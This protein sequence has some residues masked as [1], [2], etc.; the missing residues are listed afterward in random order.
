MNLN[1]KSKL[2]ILITLTI[3][4]PIT[5][6]AYLYY[7]N[8]ITGY[9]VDSFI[10]T[11]NDYKIIDLKLKEYNNNLHH[12]SNH[13]VN[14][15][16]IKSIINLISNYEDK[17]N[18]DDILFD[19]Q[20][21]KLL[22]LV[23]LQLKLKQNISFV[24]FDKNGEVIVMKRVLNGRKI[25]GI[26]SHV[27]KTHFIDL[28]TNIS[29]KIPKHRKA[30]SDNAK[31]I[32]IVL[33]KYGFALVYSQKIYMNDEFIGYIRVKQ[34]VTQINIS[35]IVK[36]LNNKFSFLSN[37]LLIGNYNNIDK[38]FIIKNGTLKN[39][40]IKTIDISETKQYFFNIHYINVLN[41]QRLYFVSAYDKKA[42]I[43]KINILKNN[44]FLAILISVVLSFLIAL[45]FL[46]IIILNPLN[47]LMIGIEKLKNK[48]YKPILLNQKD[49]FG[50]IAIE[51]NSLLENLENSFNKNK[52]SI[53]N[54]T[55][56][57][58][59]AIETIAIFDENKNIIQINES[60][61][62]MFKF[63]D[64]KEALDTNI[65]VFIP[66]HEAIKIEE[67]LTHNIT[68]QY[69]VDLKRI[70]KTIFPALVAGKN[71]LRNGKTYRITTVIDLTEIKQKDQQMFHQSRLAQM[72]EMISMIAHQWRQPLNSI[73]LTSS[74]LKFKCMMD[75]FDQDLFEKELDLIDGYSQHLS[76][77]ID[78]FRGFFKNN[79][80]KEI[81]TLEEIVDSTLDIVK[82][83]VENRNIKIITNF[84]CKKELKTYPSEIKQVILN[85]IKNA[86]D[87]LLDNEI[88]N[89]T[90][91]IE[92]LYD[93]NLDNKI[94][95]I[96]DNAGGIPEDIINNIFDPYFSTK[97][98]KDGTGLGLY[99]SKT[100]IEDHCG[101]KLSVVNDNDGAVFYITL[102]SEEKCEL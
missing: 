46:N 23:S 24:L 34:L 52:E 65:K 15:K 72:G 59:T 2:L 68:K 92:T 13:I 1:L 56:L 101:G 80:E 48:I 22:H 16:H 75:D 97:L 81:I 12:I 86:E 89:P 79:K 57:V 9:K 31:N 17:N 7:I 99:M 32:S 18:Y 10:S 88:K 67:I 20:K 50:K 41:N 94:L 29:S 39:N 4:I 61:I 54:F 102:I 53:E 78:D 60:G 19:E 6:M 63:R 91:T 74:N 30:S 64:L 36:T 37:D 21:K 73:S 96:K 44:I 69:E 100:I 43:D 35:S 51:F 77:T 76:K 70:D 14:S 93:N 3:L 71:I 58:D 83:S 33:D 95:I 42:L 84:N 47:K 85:I 82:V 11:K 90:I 49:E 98:E 66:E 40:K 55:N 27:G 62:K 26:V 25:A 5:I 38:E 28:K 45:L 8:I 87:I